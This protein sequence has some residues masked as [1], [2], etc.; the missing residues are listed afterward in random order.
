[1]RV[2]GKTM[3]HVRLVMRMAQ[4]V[5]LDLAALMRS[6]ALTQPEWAGMVHRCRGC[7]WADQCTDW[8][9]RHPQAAC[10]PINCTNRTRMAGLKARRTRTEQ[11]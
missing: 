9:D 10:A 5:G 3:H 6:G 11:V 2:L 4:A 8:L 1:M 7:D